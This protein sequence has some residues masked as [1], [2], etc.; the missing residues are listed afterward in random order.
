MQILSERL[1]NL[2]CHHTLLIFGNLSNLENYIL[3]PAL[4]HELKYIHFVLE[5]HDKFVLVHS[6]TNNKQVLN[7]FSQPNRLLLTHLNIEKLK[8]AKYL[9][10]Y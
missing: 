2:S 7:L 5:Q 3:I 9:T 10:L 4:I 1:D 6:L 8:N